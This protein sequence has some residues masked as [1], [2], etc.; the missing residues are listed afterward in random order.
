MIIY[1]DQRRMTG[2]ND[3][4][5]LSESFWRPVDRWPWRSVS[6]GWGRMD[7]HAEESGGKGDVADGWWVVS[8]L[9]IHWLVIGWLFSVI[10]TFFFVIIEGHQ[11]TSF[12]AHPTKSGYIFFIGVWRW[13][14][15]KW[16]SLCQLDVLPGN[17]VSRKT[18]TLETL[19]GLD[20]FIFRYVYV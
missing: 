7:R 12:I 8:R 2:G 4:S 17:A 9:G 5:N 1:P 14:L 13:L 18:S 10:F 3:F 6:P 20:R 16:K 11:L 19:Q 15:T